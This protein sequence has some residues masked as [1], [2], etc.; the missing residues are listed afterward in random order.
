MLVITIRDLLKEKCLG[1]DETN[2]LVQL[3]TCEGKK[4]NEWVF[5]EIKVEV[6]AYLAR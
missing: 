3:H 5:L 1:Q 4:A 2:A 6:Y